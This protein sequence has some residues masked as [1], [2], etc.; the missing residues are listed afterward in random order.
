MA[1]FSAVG[2]VFLAAAAV[3][4]FAEIGPEAYRPLRRELRAFH[5]DECHQVCRDKTVLE[6]HEKMRAE[7]RAWAKAHPDYDALD[8]RRE[9]YRALVRNF[10]PVLFRESPF[11]FE[12]GVNGGWVCGQNPA[13]IVDQLCGHFRDRDHLIPWEVRERVAERNRQRYSLV[14]G[15]LVDSI[16]HIPP[17]RRIFV[18]GFKG[19][20]D[21]V[22]ASLKTCPAWDVLGRKELETAL[23]GLDAVH[24]V[25]LR[26]A[27][28]AKR[29]L[30]V[31]EESRR[32]RTTPEV[33]SPM[34]DN[35]RR[36]VESAQRCPWEPPRTF[37]EGLNTLW[38][39]REILGLVDGTANYA[40]GRP[41]AWLIDFYRREVAAGTLTE[42]EARDLVRRFLIHADCHHDGLIPVDSYSDHE[43]EIPLTLGGCDRD[44][45]PFCNELTKIFLE[46]H[47]KMEVVFPKLHVRFSADSPKEYLEAIAG[48]VLAGHAVFA[49]FND[50]TTVPGFVK[51]G[52]P[53][54]AARDYVCCGCWDGNVDSYT[55]VDAANYMSVIRVIE[56][57]IYQDRAAMAKAQVKI[58]PIDDCASYEEVERVILRNFLRFFRD[59]CSDY[60]RY[61]RA[62]AK[63]IPSPV[64]SMCLEGGTK[65]RRDTTDG[66]AA[67]RPRVMTLAFLANAVDSM[68]AIRKVVFE[69]RFCTLKEFLDAVRGN[70]K[71]ER[72]QAIRAEA[73][74][75]PYWGDNSAASNG[76]MK[77]WIDVV[78]DDIEGLKND[79]GG[80]YVL[81]C[82]IY[83]EFMY[84]GERTKATPDGRYD[85]ERLAQGFAPSEYR[86][87]G[88][89]PDIFHALASLDHSRLYASNANLMF[90]GEG[91]DRERLAAVFRVFAGTGAH[92]LQPNCCDVET[93]LDAQRHPERHPNLMVKVCGFSARFV[94]LSRRWQDE[95]IARH[96]L[97]TR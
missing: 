13:R 36:I 61:G 92:L 71:G 19:V 68:C 95:I 40:L 11:Y 35:L 85:G 16:H 58:D 12:A 97:R 27:E 93:L 59:T 47:L 30:S 54:E 81:A 82:W 15:P 10:R 76:L 62:N 55:D 49:M 83:R 31:V 96:R 56:E 28:E 89:V 94:A 53:L 88:D 43:A 34:S 65:T 44:G 66:G 33:S 57:T 48:E 84:W 52:L 41:D 25:Q 91:L 70:W 3:G 51:L 60:T 17:F 87:K 21:E 74:K 1:L 24:E 67:F 86:N 29:Q 37:Y 32:A 2:S 14:C 77:K 72:A 6:S 45:R 18:L 90:G 39:M 38:F 26:F 46:E 64:Y 5:P 73:L 20:R 75:A 69:D 7:V 42:A 79:Q 4:N 9:Y 23:V 50:D 78:A 8:V 63:V 80:P 22:E